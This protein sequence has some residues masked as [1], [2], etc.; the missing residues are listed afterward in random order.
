MFFHELKYEFKNNIRQKE[1]I[2]WLFCFP[3]VLSTFFNLAFGS[4]FEKNEL[5]REIPVAVVSEENESINYSM[6]KSVMDKMELFAPIYT[7]NDDA[8]EKLKTGDVNG[9]ICV[10]EKLSVKVS[11]NGTMAT[12]IKSFAE[13]YE[14]QKSV[15]TETAMTNPQNVEAVVNALSNEISCIKTKD[16]GSENMDAFVSYFFNLIAMVSLFATTSG[17]NAATGN[18]GNLSPI[19]A[20]KCISPA[21]KLVSI[22]ACLSAAYIT[23]ILCTTTSITYILFVLKV[24]MGTNYPMIYLTGIITPILGTSL[25]FFIGSIG[26]GSQ[27]AKIGIAMAVTM[28]CCFLSGL[29]VGDMKSVIEENIPIINRINP[30]ALI[31]DLFYCLMIYDNYDRYIRTAMLVLGFTVLYTTGGFLLTRRKKYASI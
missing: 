11:A 6:L 5:L 3:I 10:G 9:I 15:I 16:T 20:R 14:A 26:R 13:Q 21:N 23:Q 25:G 24:N 19:G 31:S 1:V 22:L 18:Q 8:L 30:A 29:M 27:G 4:I 2:F 7:D 17:I 12:I 28:F